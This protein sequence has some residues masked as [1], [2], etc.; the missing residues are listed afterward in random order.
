MKKLL[1][2]LIGCIFLF[3]AT[4]Q[5]DK[6]DKADTQDEVIDDSQDNFIFLHD[7]FYSLISYDNSGTKASGWDDTDYSNAYF[8]DCTSCAIPLHIQ[9]VDPA[10]TNGAVWQFFGSDTNG[11]RGWSFNPSTQQAVNFV[12]HVDS[13]F[14][15]TA[16]ITLTLVSFI[17]TTS[18]DR[19]VMGF[20]AVTSSGTSSTVTTTQALSGFTASSSQNPVTYT[21]NV[22]LIVPATT[23]TDDDWV[24]WSVYR[25]P[26]DSTDNASVR[27]CVLDYL[28]DQ[29]Q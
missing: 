19:A 10:S 14:D 24:S 23:F 28:L 18:T 29:T 8:N 9:D 11:A 27:F 12:H 1:I 13:A 17:T 4:W 22:N 7:L 6:P 26:D 3:S 5:D 25:V 15:V 16:S 2:V 20:T 21:S